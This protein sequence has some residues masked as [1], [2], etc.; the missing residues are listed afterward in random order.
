M[1]NNK[2]EI[3]TRE[4]DNRGIK[5]RGAVEER[6]SRAASAAKITGL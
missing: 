6:P 3:A 2:P 1:S 5:P 4:R